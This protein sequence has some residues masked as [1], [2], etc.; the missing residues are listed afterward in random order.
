[1][2]GRRA[3]E[4]NRWKRQADTC[5]EETE[6]PRPPHSTTWNPQA[7]LGESLS[8]RQTRLRLPRPQQRRLRDLFL[9]EGALEAAERLFLRQEAAHLG[10][11]HVAFQS[12]LHQR[13]RHRYE[14]VRNMSHRCC[15]SYSVRG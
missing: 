7:A 4:P 3:R 14:E 10:S 5:A 1:M 15:T 8:P 12:N 11:F 9:E 2:R 13:Y 6:I